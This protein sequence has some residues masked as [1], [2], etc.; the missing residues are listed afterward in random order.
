MLQQL[1]LLP[2]SSAP[3]QLFHNFFKMLGINHHDILQINNSIKSFNCFSSPVFIKLCVHN[4]RGKN[5]PMCVLCGGADCLI[6]TG[7]EAAGRPSS[8][9]S[10]IGRIMGLNRVTQTFLLWIGRL[11]SKQGWVLSVLSKM[12]PWIIGH[13]PS[14]TLI[15]FILTHVMVKDVPMEE[16]TAEK[17]FCTSQIKRF[18]FLKNNPILPF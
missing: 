6:V 5:S 2:I 1:Q 10:R 12:F 8:H 3:H 11:E 14:N 18:D 13:K 17:S 15:E 16:Q 7:G 4:I 9:P